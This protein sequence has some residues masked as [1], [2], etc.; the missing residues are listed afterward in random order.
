MEFKAYNRNKGNRYCGPAVVSFLTGIETDDA[1]ALIRSKSGQRAIRGTSTRA[2]LAALA[3]C[4]IK[5]ERRQGYARRTLAAWLQLTVD[6]RTAGR[7][8]LVV[9]GHHFQLVSGRRYACSMVAEVCSVR[10]KRVKRRARVAE[11]FELTGTPDAREAL[12]PIKA[13]QERKRKQA[14]NAAGCRRE[15]KRLEAA[16]VCT[17]EVDDL[18]D[19]VRHIYVWPGKAFAGALDLEE[20]DPL[21]GQ[22][23]AHDWNDALHNAEVYERLLETVTHV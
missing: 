2:L 4:G 3:A 1:A 17:I 16:G 14:A 9:A 11:V 18:G 19:G 10:D 22:R 20:A 8:W 13:A 23:I 6:E 7:M 15:V 12:K 5:A 21:S